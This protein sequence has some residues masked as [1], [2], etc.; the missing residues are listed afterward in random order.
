MC[1]FNRRH[2]TRPRNRSNRNHPRHGARL[3]SV[4]L[5]E[6]QE[7][8]ER[9]EKTTDFNMSFKYTYIHVCLMEYVKS[10]WNILNDFW[11]KINHILSYD[12][13]LINA[14]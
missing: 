3:L 7:R 9:L 11:V 2:S 1:H 4:T 13:M 10:G 12:V 14:Y 6:L 8:A 5:Q